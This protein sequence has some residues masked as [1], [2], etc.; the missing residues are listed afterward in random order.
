[1]KVDEAVMTLKATGDVY[2]PSLNLSLRVNTTPW[3]AAAPREV[4][5][6]SILKNT[7]QMSGQRRAVIRG[8]SLVEA[9]TTALVAKAEVT[10]VWRVVTILALTMT[11]RGTIPSMRAMVGRTPTTIK[12]QRTA[13]STLDHP[14]TVL[15]SPGAQEDAQSLSLS[16]RTIEIED[17]R[18]TQTQTLAGR[19]SEE[20]NLR[21]EVRLISLVMTL[22]GA[23]DLGPPIDATM[24]LLSHL[25]AST[26]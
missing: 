18:K 6:K 5:R 1:M 21:R 16:P 4:T 11:G 23:A 9:A 25:G 13:T 14:G 2:D 17:L 22:A 10:T 19:V 3:I 12:S 15:L 24:T 7:C 20:R 26:L 8:E